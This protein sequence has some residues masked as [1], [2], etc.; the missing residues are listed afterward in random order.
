MHYARWRGIFYVVGEGCARM[1]AVDWWLRALLYTGDEAVLFEERRA[2]W[3]G[4]MN[5]GF[6]VYCILCIHIKIEFK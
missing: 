5:R 4:M 2:I 1:V 3:R 6:Y